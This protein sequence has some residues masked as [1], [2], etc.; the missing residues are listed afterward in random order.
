[1]SS[2]SPDSRTPPSSDEF[3]D[4]MAMFPAGVNVLSTSVDGEPYATTAT[5][6]SSLSVEPLLVMVALGRDSRLLE[7]VRRTRLLGISYL[8]A[9][10]RDTAVLL[11]GRMKDCAAVTWE[12]IGGLPAVREARAFLGT[13]IDRF[14]PAG[15]HEILLCAV[16]VVQKL[17][18]GSA[19]LLYHERQFVSV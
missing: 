12:S 4:V 13:R 6:F 7:H 16:D 5:A 15:D 3:R 9:D 17:N 11:A 18:S 1:M 14:I 19:P 8:H 2:S 10:Q